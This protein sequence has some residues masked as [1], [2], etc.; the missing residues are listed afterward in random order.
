M[1]QAM[2]K[3]LE[4]QKPGL[5]MRVLAVEEGQHVLMGGNGRYVIKG[6]L[7]DLWD[8]VQETGTMQENQI[9]LPAAL[10][11][12]QF[13]VSLGNPQR[14]TVTIIMKSNCSLCDTVFA[15]LNDPIQLDRYHYQVMLVSN[16]SDSLRASQ[17]VY[18]AEDRKAALETV[19]A[20]PGASTTPSGSCDSQ[21]PVMTTKVAMAMQVRALP[22]THFN[23]KHLTVIGDPSAYL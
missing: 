21:L 23:D 6:Q 16:D 15:V 3:A 20:S 7:K 8:G 1:H 9:T 18:C 12:E 17:Y 10:E 13:F 19:L 22:Y 4:Q 11:P 5:G 14:P 2:V